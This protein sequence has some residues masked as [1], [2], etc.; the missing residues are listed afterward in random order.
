MLIEARFRRDST[1]HDASFRSETWC[2][3]HTAVLS[4]LH[5]ARR[6]S[7]DKDLAFDERKRRTPRA[8][9]PHNWRGLGKSWRTIKIRLFC[10]SEK[11]SLEVF[12]LFR[13]ARKLRSV[14]RWRRAG[15]L[16]FY[17]PKVSR[18]FF[19]SFFGFARFFGTAFCEMINL[20]RGVSAFGESSKSISAKIEP[21]ARKHFIHFRITLARGVCSPFSYRV[22]RFRTRRVYGE[23]FVRL[24][25][26]SN[27]YN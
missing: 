8:A 25:I 13:C 18:I 4:I 16:S 23:I 17:S 10:P 20:D 27:K 22:L 5:G 6:W 15:R 2:N 21:L 12:L 11:K 14:S 19:L 24:E 7:L 9:R 3:M 26:S 1:K